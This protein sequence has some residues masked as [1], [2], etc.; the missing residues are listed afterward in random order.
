MAWHIGWVQVFNILL[1]SI[2]Y[3][4]MIPLKFFTMLHIARILDRIISYIKIDLSKML[5]TWSL[6]RAQG[7]NPSTHVTLTHTKPVSHSCTHINKACAYKPRHR[8]LH[9]LVRERSTITHLL[10]RVAV[11]AIDGCIRAHQT[12][13][14]CKLRGVSGRRGSRTESTLTTAR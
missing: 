6:K 4:F 14:R 2:Y 1:K 10:L 13:I 8:M 11:E 12:N 5:N 7:P 3:I 9:L